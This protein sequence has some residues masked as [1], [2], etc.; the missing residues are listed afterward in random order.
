MTGNKSTILDR[1]LK[2]R[3]FLGDVGAVGLVFLPG[4]STTD[5]HSDDNGGEIRA[6][7]TQPKPVTWLFTGDSVT[8]GALHTSG[9][10]SYPEHFA[11]RVRWELSRLR[12]III[13]S[14]VSGGTT[15]ALLK[16][17]EWRIFQFKPHVTSLMMGVNDC[18]A[19][20]SGRDD[21]RQNLN[22]LA[23][24]IEEHRSLPLLHTPNL[25]HYPDAERRKDLPAYVE[26]I[27]EVAK[28]RRILVVDHYSH[29]LEK[30][31]SA[32]DRDDLLYLLH[33]GSIHPN[34]YGHRELANLLFQKLGIYDPASRTCRLFVG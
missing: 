13:N 10:R 24:A 34:Q 27:R 28:Q 22:K 9:C 31:N 8:Q 20:P 23:E 21:F 14:A 3:S 12:D 2:R 25:I 16:D 26:I 19:G 1:K 11:E 4:V 18:V 29:W 33:D 7:L 6:L 30:V 17:L 5:V 15:G 32:K